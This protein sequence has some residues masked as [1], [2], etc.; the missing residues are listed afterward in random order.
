MPTWKS[1]E[2]NV[3]GVTIIIISCNILTLIFGVGSGASP[4]EEILISSL[5]LG[6]HFSL[7]LVAW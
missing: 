7:I 1:R 4:F 5:N 6:D 3:V 2:T